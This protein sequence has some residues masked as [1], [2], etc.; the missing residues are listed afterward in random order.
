M[1]PK[2]HVLQSLLP[3]CP[4]LPSASWL[5]RWVTLLSASARAL[6]VLCCLTT[7]PRQSQVTMEQCQNPQD[8][9]VKQACAPSSDITMTVA[10]IKAVASQLVC[11]QATPRLRNHAENQK[12]S[13]PMQKQAGGYFPYPVRRAF[14]PLS[15]P[16]SRLLEISAP[17]H[18]GAG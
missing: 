10:F 18:T 3:G 17:A 6:A 5:S 11:L 1:S 15:E 14:N 4:I 7:G 13:P 8:C 2:P 16:L 9:A 12:S